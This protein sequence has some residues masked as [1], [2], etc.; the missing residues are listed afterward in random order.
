MTKYFHIAFMRYG[1]GLSGPMGGVQQFSKYLKR[2]IPGMQLISFADMP[3]WRNY[4]EYPDYDKA[5]VLNQW[6]LKHGV[7]DKDSVVIVDG[8]WGSGLQG[9]VGRLI[10]VCHGSYFGRF[11]MHQIS[12]WGEVVGMDQVEAQI[13]FWKDPFVETVLVAKEGQRE[14]RLAGC[15]TSKMTIIHHGVDLEVLRPMPE[16]EKTCLMHAATGNRKGLDIFAM[17]DSLGIV[18]EF[19]NETSGK[20]ENKAKRLNEARCLIAPTRHEGNAY[21]LI[22]ALACGVPIITYYTGFATE[23]DERCGVV[24]DNMDPHNWKRLIDKFNSGDYDKQLDPR[25][26]AEANCDLADFT[27]NWRVYLDCSG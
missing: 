3:N 12:P 6:L 14:L 13:T 8:Y 19:M 10:S 2:A 16:I 1:D 20:L 27:I 21:I 5:L 22:E 26:F 18:V 24:T 7:L 23:F 25:E 15:D 9:Y 4:M 17:L 11:V